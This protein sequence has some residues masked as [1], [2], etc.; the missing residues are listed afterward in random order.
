MIL[1]VAGPSEQQ[2]RQGSE[3]LLELWM[4]VRLRSE[5]GSIRRLLALRPRLGELPLA[6]LQ[7]LAI[8]PGEGM[9]EQAPSRA[10]ENPEHR[11]AITGLLRRRLLRRQ[12][13][14][15]RGP[16]LMLTEQGREARRTMDEIQRETLAVLEKSLTPEQLEQLYET[17]AAVADSGPG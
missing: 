16:V 6:Q 8:I 11:Q 1:S 13:D 15:V 7:L 4:L 9:P 5:R 3:S 2:E 12:V 10:R 17:L 14:G